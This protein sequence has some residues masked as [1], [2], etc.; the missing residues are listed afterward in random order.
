MTRK[1]S[2]SLDSL[3]EKGVQF[4]APAESEPRPDIE[5][6]VLT[7]LEVTR[8]REGMGEFL[9]ELYFLLMKNPRLVDALLGWAFQSGNVT[10]IAADMKIDRRDVQRLLDT[11]RGP[12]TPDIIKRIMGMND[13]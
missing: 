6:I 4:E 8:I 9:R 11:L 5:N 12:D 7:D 1:A 13:D 3:V 10:R 2:V